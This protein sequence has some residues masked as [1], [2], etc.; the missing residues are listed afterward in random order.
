M[1]RIFPGKIFWIST[2]F[3]SIFFGLIVAG[4]ILYIAFQENPQGEFFDTASGKINIGNVLPLFFSA[5][6]SSILLAAGV[7]VTIMILFRLSKGLTRH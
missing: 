1:T 4:A 2:A 3:A 6:A 5:F 7:I